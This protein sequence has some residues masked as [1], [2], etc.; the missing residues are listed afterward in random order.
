MYNYRSRYTKD[1][2]YYKKPFIKTKGCL[3][4]LILIIA[5]AGF[6]YWSMHRTPTAPATQPKFTDQTVAPDRIAQLTSFSGTLEIKTSDKP[7][8]GADANATFQTGDTARTDGNS[9]ASILLPDKSIIRLSE[10]SQVQFIELSASNIT[11]EQKNGNV[12]HRVNPQTTAIYRVKNNDAEL[13]ALGT[14]FNVLSSGALTYVT[15]IDSQVQVKIYGGDSVLNVRTL[16]TGTRA[17]LN[18]T[19]QAD[20][21]IKTEDVTVA[22]LVDDSWIMW[23][24]AQDKQ[25]NAPLGLFANALKLNINQPNKTEITTAENKI[26]VKGQTETDARVFI[27]GREINNDNGTFSADLTL[28]PGENKIGVVVQRNKDKNKQTLTITST[29]KPSDANA[30]VAQ[31]SIALSATANSNNVNLGWTANNQTDT[32]TAFKTIISQ[33]ADPAYPGNSYHSI[34]RDKSSDTWQNLNPGA[35]HFRVCLLQNNQC[36]IYSNDATALIK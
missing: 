26:T 34:D 14:G 32:S 30:T 3:L 2:S 31:N 18:T 23:N 19:L 7:W 24:V 22:D 15:V 1:Q 28:T 25:N 11:I 12:F 21:T 16:A 17:T 29:A 8:T 9:R 20:Q 36:V 10:N 27:S 33:T 6:V 5:I 4:L 35:Y 13:T